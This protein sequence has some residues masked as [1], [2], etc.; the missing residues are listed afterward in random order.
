MIRLYLAQLRRDRLQLTIWILGIS[1]LLFAATRTVSA[2][3]DTDAKL[4]QIVTIALATPSILA[5][6]GA[7]NGASLGSM[8]FFS[9]F[10]NVAVAAGLMNT[11][12][13]TR[14]ARGDEERGRRE[15]I[16]AAPVRRSASLLATTLLGLTADVALGGLA[17]AA[18][19]AGGLDATGSVVAGAAI[20]ATGLAFLGVGLFVGELAATSRAANSVAA[21]AVVVSYVLRAAG[22]A[23][24]EPDLRALS[25][26]SAW[27]SWLSPIGWGQQSF[28]FTSNRLW[29]LALSS[30]LAAAGM[31]AALL[32]H[33]R[34]ELGDG[35]LPERA[36]PAT[37]R[38][39]LRSPFGLAWRLQWPSLVG[40][41]IGTASFGFVA[42]FLA[43]A[44]GNASFDNPGIVALLRS[45]G[46]GSRADLV[47]LFLSAIMVI[48]SLLASA[49]ALQSVL[50][51]R[52]EESSGRAEFALSAPVSRVRWL[53]AAAVVGVISATTVMVA[54][55]LATWI[56]FLAA[57]D[58]DG[59]R[60]AVEQALL[61][62]PV[63]LVFVGVGALVVAALPRISVGLTWGL[64][65]LA[66]VVGMFGGLLQLPQ[67]VLDVSPLTHVPS[68]PVGDWAGVIGL[69]VVAAATLVTALVVIRRRD[70][71]T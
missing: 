57:G 51:L 21:T 69:I 50:K 8:M 13:V 46:H 16:A 34:R 49:A 17:A 14:H 30:G 68:V 10:A 6:R 55:G 35:L 37:A 2:E 58:P 4:V 32:V 45:L 19:M 59:G 64:F 22:D 23:L 66:I 70:L 7:P 27:P 39:T 42:G 20:G 15:L 5:L 29:P 44:I 38:R 47:S 31:G 63:G 48:V 12:L 71:S 26:R 41:A 11:F 25:L 62:L 9:I 18:F 43:T 24:G 67:T 61:E 33:S 28:A 1:L 52:D 40:W 36:G 65:G 56:S 3:F 53:S 60:R 54:C